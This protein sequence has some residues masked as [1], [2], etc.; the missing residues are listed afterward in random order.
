M[1]RIKITEARK[2]HQTRTNK[3]L[4]NKWIAAKVFTDDRGKELSQARKEALLSRWDNGHDFGQLTP[5]RLLR[6]A[7]VFGNTVDDMIS[8]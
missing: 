2:A 8:A 7:Q 3:K 5:G 1:E 4:T 6:L